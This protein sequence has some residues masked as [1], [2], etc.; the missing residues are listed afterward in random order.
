MF[1]KM[2]CV[3]GFLFLAQINNVFASDEVPPATSQDLPDF[4]VKR[5]E[6]EME[7]CFELPD[8]KSKECIADSDSDDCKASKK[9]PKNGTE[10][11]YVP[12]ETCAKRGGQIMMTVRSQ[13]QK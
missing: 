4:L 7:K 5:P 12:R 10:F 2:V 1:R 8:A 11:T 13:P 9:R 6:A 3:V